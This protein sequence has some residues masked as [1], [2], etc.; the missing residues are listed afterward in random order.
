MGNEKLPSLYF[1]DFFLLEK[2]KS[3]VFRYVGTE[4]RGSRQ[5]QLLSSQGTFYAVH[6]K[7]N[8]YAAFGVRGIL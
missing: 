2:C 8:R 4:E 5:F 1:S 3:P 7:V 6:V